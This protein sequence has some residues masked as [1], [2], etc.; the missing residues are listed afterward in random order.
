MHII[1]RDRV[2]RDQPNEVLSILHKCGYLD[3]TATGE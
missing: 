3:L 1:G 2:P